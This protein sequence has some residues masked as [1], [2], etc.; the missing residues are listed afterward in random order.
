MNVKMKLFCCLLCICMIV[1]VFAGCGTDINKNEK[2]VS[3]RPLSEKTDSNTNLDDTTKAEYT[4][5]ATKWSGPEGYTIVLPENE[6][7]Q[8]QESAE[9]LNKYFL[10]KYTNL[11]I[12]IPEK[13]IVATIK[14]LTSNCRAWTDLVLSAS[15]SSSPSCPRS[16]KKR[17]SVACF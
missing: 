7:T 5:E 8:Y 13:S 14:I 9:L 2:Y 1:S 11:P 12:I 3:D 4:Y 16:L 6:K 17:C 15:F 10:E